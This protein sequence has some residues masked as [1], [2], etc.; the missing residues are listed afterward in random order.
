MCFR[1]SA[2]QA[3]TVKSIKSEFK[4]S[5]NGVKDNSNAL[6]LVNSRKETIFHHQNINNQKKINKKWKVFQEKERERESLGDMILKIQKPVHLGEKD[7]INNL[8]RNGCM[9]NLIHFAVHIKLMQTL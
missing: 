2:Y 3:A 9:H 6:L 7:K 5:V 4:C 8:K 1:I